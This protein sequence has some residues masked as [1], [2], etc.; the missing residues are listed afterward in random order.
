LAVSPNNELR[1]AAIDIGTNS[2]LLTIAEWQDGGFRVLVDQATVTRL[3]QGVDQ[4]RQLMPAAIDRSVDCLRRYAQELASYEVT[5][6]DIVGTSALRDAANADVFLRQAELLFNRRP[7]VIDGRQEASLTCQGAL[8][9]LSVDGPFVVVDV[10]GG[11]TEFIVGYRTNTRVRLDH[12][13]SL[14]IGC[15]RLTERHLS[16][17]PPSP[18]EL[19]RLTQDAT[20]ALRSLPFDI[21]SG[22]LIGVAGTVTTLC[23][24][25]FG[26]V[27][28]A[29]ERVHDARLQ[30]ETI[31][32]QRRQLS[33]LNHS[34][35]ALIRGLHA[36][37]ADVIVAGAIIVEQVLR[38]S[39]RSE[40]VVSDHGVRYGLLARLFHETEMT[41][42]DR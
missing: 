16:T 29:P 9:N 40:L 14:D 20:S 11:S 32:E 1:V 33:R 2:I 8:S 38:L 3:G 35:R 7:R 42:T 17:D 24:M 27:P 37:R 28:Y 22:T 30:L 39:R 18:E 4:T 13:T 21:S 23:A 31:T 19:E 6:L 25:H 36:G 34:Q 10:G 12:F 26:L 5:R 41:R 15:V